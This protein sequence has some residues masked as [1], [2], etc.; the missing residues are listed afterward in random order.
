VLKVYIAIIIAF[1]H[2]GKKERK[3]RKWVDEIMRR[4]DD[5]TMGKDKL[6]TVFGHLRKC[7][8]IY[9]CLNF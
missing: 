2:R 1:S 8:P 3:M 7:L 4:W 9:S 5:V 6:C